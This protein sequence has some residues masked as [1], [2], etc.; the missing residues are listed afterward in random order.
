MSTNTA[1]A[2]TAKPM[3][4]LQTGIAKILCLLTMILAILDG[5]IVSA[6]IVP[7][8]RDL[9]PINGINQVTWLVA[10]FTLAATVM[11]PLYG[12]LC[13][14]FGP[15]RVLIAALTVFMAGS[16]LCGAATTMTE[17]IA[18]RMLQGVGAGGL[19][20]VTMVLMFHVM[21]GGK[22]K[23]PGAMA[24]L[25]AG[26]GMAIG[27]LV[28]GLFA[29]SGNWRWIF[30]INLPLGLAIVAGLLWAVRLPVHTAKTSLDLLGAAL[31]AGF[32]GALLMACEWGGTQ[33]SWTSP[34]IIE[35]LA[36]SVLCL[37]LF[38]WRQAT[39][40]HPILPLALFRL[41]AV[42]LG[43]VIQGLIGIVMTGAMINLMVYLQI[44]RGIS[45]TDA[46]VYLAFMAAGLMVSGLLGDKLGFATRTSM[47]IGTAF[48]TIA[49]A[50]LATTGDH[51]SLWLIR[52]ELVVLGLGFG[53]LLGKLITVV[54]SAVPRHQL[55][56]ATTGIRFFQSLGGA[57]GAAAAGSLL[58]TC[59]AAD[60]PGVSMSALGTLT[61]AAHQQALNAF[62][63]GIDI[64]FIAAAVLAALALAL[65]SRLRETPAAEL[66]AQPTA[67]RSAAPVLAR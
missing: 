2:D 41:R 62:T 44:A 20:S 1:P 37:A 28:G 51:T 42:R 53:Q 55:G 26:F 19:M 50:G 43:Y 40:A 66:V 18:F 13:D 12:R 25:M 24:G 67:T 46:G 23:G 45:A 59:F 47:I 56:V 35:L 3:S 36:A 31:V 9:D 52:G 33:Y 16:A 49:L 8:V 60:D 7:I 27:P 14:L 5:N 61:S 30:Y 21:G 57:V 39:A 34:V 22:G 58:N 54:Q 15:K 38:L 48:L 10:G 64:V 4:P 65:T 29:D 6:A 11:L 63:S 17:L 32:A